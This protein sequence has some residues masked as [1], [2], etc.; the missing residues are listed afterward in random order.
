M[1][2]IVGMTN[3]KAISF[4]II[5]QTRFDLPRR[6]RCHFLL[7]RGIENSRSDCHF[8]A[9]SSISIRLGPSVIQNRY[10]AG[11]LTSGTYT[12]R[13]IVEL[14]LIG[15]LVGPKPFAVFGAAGLATRQAL[16]W[17]TDSR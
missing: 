6:N 4:R 8:F 11:L 9:F 2:N 17:A 3:S 10:C 14:S 5:A 16:Y 13:E 15:F 1:A 12:D 7:I